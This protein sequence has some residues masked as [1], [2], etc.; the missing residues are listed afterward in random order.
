MEAMFLT[1]QSELRKVYGWKDEDDRC[2]VTGQVHIRSSQL[3]ARNRS[4]GIQ[5]DF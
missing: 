5:F 3:G 4:H 1:D 2:Q